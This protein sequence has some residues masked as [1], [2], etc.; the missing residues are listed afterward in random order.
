VLIGPDTKG[1]PLEEFQSVKVAVGLAR[2]RARDLQRREEREA[3]E[4]E[5]QKK[6]EEAAAKKQ[7]EVELDKLRKDVIRM[8]KTTQAE[9]KLD[10]KGMLQAM[11][12]AS[13]D[14][15]IG[16]TELVKFVRE[17]EK[18]QAAKGENGGK[19]VKPISDEDLSDL[20]EYLDSED[21]GFL[22]EEKFE[23][24]I[25]QF[26]KVVKPTILTKEIGLKSDS[27]R[28]IEAEELVEV[29]QGPIVEESVEVG[30]MQV[31]ATSDGVEGWLTPVGNQGT[32]YLDEGGHMFKVVKETILTNCFVIGTDKEETRKLKEST[33]KVKV[34][35]VVECCEW[36]RKDENGLERMKVRVK[37]DDTIGWATSV[38]NTGIVFL[39]V[40]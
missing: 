1:V 14:T 22:S 19:E 36:A 18:T 32:V 31:K 38:G 23:N 35:E 9:L 37:S 27:L 8:I 15:R 40:M 12:P 29:L 17:Y 10:N 33:R 21:D 30:R 39:E 4:R 6:K 24:M 3:K 34:G 11:A 16:E 20:F 26:M 2:E 25:R 28:R 5:L 13:G 7:R